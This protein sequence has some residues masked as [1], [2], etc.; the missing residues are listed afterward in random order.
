MAR[1]NAF[2]LWTAVMSAFRAEN[3]PIMYRENISGDETVDQVTYTVGLP[4]EL[5]ESGATEAHVNELVET[6]NVGHPHDVFVHAGDLAS[7][8]GC[9]LETGRNWLQKFNQKGLLRMHGDTDIMLEEGPEGVGLYLPIRDDPK[10]I[11]RSLYEIEE[12]SYP[13]ALGDLEPVTPGQFIHLGGGEYA[14]EED[15][16]IVID[17]EKPEGRNTTLQEYVEEQLHSHGLTASS[18]KNFVY[19]LRKQASLI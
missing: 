18:T 16:D 2:E 15:R 8:T 12:G 4:A 5:I 11:M 14:Y 1:Y 7:L 17:V 9:S 19:K 13:T 3:K 6:K 10:Q